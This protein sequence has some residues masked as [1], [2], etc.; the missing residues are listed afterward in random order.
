MKQSFL[1]IIEDVI[2]LI[3]LMIV[4]RRHD[5]IAF[6]RKAFASDLDHFYGSKIAIINSEFIRKIMSNLQDEYLEQ[7][8]CFYHRDKLHRRMRLTKKY[9]KGRQFAKYV[10]GGVDYFEF[11]LFCPC[12]ESDA[13]VDVIF[14]ENYAIPYIEEINKSMF[15]ELASIGAWDTFK[16]SQIRAYGPPATRVL[17]VVERSTGCKLISENC[18]RISL[19]KNHL[20]KSEKISLMLYAFPGTEYLAPIGFTT[21]LSRLN[22]LPKCKVFVKFKARNFSVASTYKNVKV[23]WDSDI[24]NKKLRQCQ[25]GVTF[26]SITF[27]EMLSNDMLVVIPKFLDTKLPENLLQLGANDDHTLKTIKIAY[28]FEEFVKII[29]TIDLDDL[30]KNLESERSA[31]LKLIEQAF[32][33]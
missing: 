15:E 8:T 20:F 32:Y 29:D 28:S 19:K 23:I 12:K 22:E 1:R 2:V 17:E 10:F 30:E 21:L 9:L 16:I 27:Y 13:F 5:T 25:I 31:R 14:H 33:V 18:P 3:Y 6:S 26:N 11:I 24:A 4:T 7:I